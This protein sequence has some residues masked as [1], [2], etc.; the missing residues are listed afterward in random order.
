MVRVDELLPHSHIE[1]GQ[2]SEDL[3]LDLKKGKN[4][5]CH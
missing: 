2:V 4:M 1:W 5:V 3:S